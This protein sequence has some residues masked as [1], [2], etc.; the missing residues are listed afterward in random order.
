MRIIF[1]IAAMLLLP[2]PAYA[3]PEGRW[4]CQYTPDGQPTESWD[5]SIVGGRVIEKRNAPLRLVPDAAVSD[6]YVFWHS[7]GSGGYAEFYPKEGRFVYTFP[8]VS[9]DT[10][11]CARKP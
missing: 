7:G 4:Q 5:V 11:T 8:G 2:L 1:T 9:I 3:A 10:Y 6:D